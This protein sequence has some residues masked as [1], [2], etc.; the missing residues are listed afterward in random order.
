MKSLSMSVLYWVALV[1]LLPTFIE[2]ISRT[3]ASCDVNASEDQP[4]A[5]ESAS[6]ISGHVLNHENKPLSEAVVSLYRFHSPSQR[7]GHFVPAAPPATTDMS[8][9][10]RFENLAD[11]YYLIAV[12]AEGYAH[13]HSTRAI[14]EGPTTSTADV[15]M[16]LPVAVAIDLKDEAGQPIEG[17][18]IRSFNRSGMNGSI[19]ATQMLLRDLNF[20]VPASNKEGRIVL[21]DFPQNETLRLTIA[22]PNFAPIVIED[23]KVTN[24]VLA[25]AVMKPGVVLTFQRHADES[26]ERI[27]NAVLDLRHSNFES[28]STILSYEVDFDSSGKG[29][30][31]IE[32]GDYEFLRLQHDDFYL[33]PTL[34]ARHGKLNPN[35][36]L[37]FDAGRNVEL[38]FE[39]HRRLVAKGRVIDAESSEPVAEQSLIGKILTGVS[40]DE[41]DQTEFNFTGWGESNAQGEFTVP[42]AKG[43][44]R[45]E[46]HGTNYLSDTEFIDFDVTADHAMVIPDIKVRSIPKLHGVVRDQDGMPAARVVVRVRGQVRGSKNIADPVLTD[47]RGRFEIQPTYVLR[48]DQT[49]QRQLDYSV[50][51]F[52][53]FRPFSGRAEVKLDESKPIELWLEPHDFDWPLTE[54]EGELS[55]WE[56][57]NIT[58][59]KAAENDAHSLRGQPIPELDFVEWINSE[60]LDRAK[61][62][63]HYV[64]LDFWFIGCGPCHA[65]FPV[66]KMLHELYHD[67]GLIVIGV[68]NNNDPPEKVRQH[69]QKIGLPYP[70][71]VD[72][73]DGRTVRAFQSHRLVEG[74]PSYVLI[75]PE[76]NVLLDDRTI[77]HPSLRGYK[78]E[79]L[80]KLLFRQSPE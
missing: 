75:D 11:G 70:I 64:L 23:L 32:P 42:V 47:D 1:F 28:P 7:F 37:H 41:Q 12:Q 17:A 45:I 33:T 66:V 58:A 69:V 50:V 15:R 14:N 34:H 10:F 25:S 2:S 49:N 53:P 4:E 51:A 62:R 57:G 27:E 73:P 43:R 78:L 35:H 52:D 13:S 20:N 22:H 3:S 67:R 40:S 36:P 74:F 38:R 63:G 29:S 26:E 9:I 19:H 21:A 56:R 54:F 80:R 16:Q 68:H 76:G 71:A 6:T 59:E 79:I 8:G 77:P 65:E 72:H 60:P 44:M 48:N 55:E 24:G 31:T 18:W 46:F 61:F 30:V 5:Q 39:V